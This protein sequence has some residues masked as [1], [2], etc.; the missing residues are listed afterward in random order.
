MSKLLR[1]PS[2]LVWGTGALTNTVVNGSNR[3]VLA[4]GAPVPIASAVFW[5]TCDDVAAIGASPLGPNGNVVL[6]PA[7]AAG[8]FNDGVDSDAANYVWWPA[9]Q[10]VGVSVVEYWWR[11]GFSHGDAVLRSM[12]YGWDTVHAKDAIYILKNGAVYRYAV[13][14]YENG[15]AK[16]QYRYN[17]M[18]YTAGNLYHMLIIFNSAA[19]A[20]NRVK[21]YKDTVLQVPTAHITDAA[22]TFG[23]PMNCYFS[24]PPSAIDSDGV[25]DNPKIYNGIGDLAAIFANRNT[26]GWP[27]GG[28]VANGNYESPVI[29]CGAGERPFLIGWTRSAYVDDEYI[30]SIRIRGSNDAPTGAA[31]GQANDDDA[32]PHDYWS[33]PVWTPQNWETLTLDVE[34]VTH[35]RYIQFQANL[36][37]ATDLEDTPELQTLRM[38][39][40]SSEYAAVSQ[41][42]RIGERIKS[43]HLEVGG[44]DLAGGTSTLKFP[45]FSMRRGRGAAGL[46]LS[47]ASFSLENASGAFNVGNPDAWFGGQD[48]YGMSIDA[49]IE[50]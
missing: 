35:Y 3:I 38:L 5:N 7:F 33:A 22:Y 13:F 42:I 24:N 47:S 20:T 6:A 40:R 49:W 34:P 19:G 12:Y 16:V 36:V 23:G 10:P 17:N 44:V 18:T 9:S 41:S 4:A 1:Q 25:Y 8:K 48:V 15:V 45:T 27:G 30:E 50:L 29:D 2:Q 26:E 43:Y 28:F 11:P 14:C 39:F 21:V 31:T 37:A 46:Q 32:T